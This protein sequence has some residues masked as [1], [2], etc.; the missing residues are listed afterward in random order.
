[1]SLQQ[2]KITA[3]Y[4][5]LSNDDGNAGDSDSIINQRSIVTKYAQDNGFHNIV[6]FVDDGYSGGNFQRP[7]FQRMIEL[8]KNGEVGSIIVKDYQDLAGNTFIW[9]CI[10]SSY[11]QAI[12]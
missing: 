5:R 10:Q 8:V 7:S 4:L 6:E 3:I 1:M 11:F 9:G 12:T 2:T